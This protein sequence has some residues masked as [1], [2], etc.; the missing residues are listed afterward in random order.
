MQNKQLS[1]RALHL[2]TINKGAAL[3][4]FPSRR[5]RNNPFWP[6]PKAPKRPSVGLHHGKPDTN[7]KPRPANTATV[8]KQNRLWLIPFSGKRLCLFGTPLNFQPVC[9]KFAIQK[10]PS[11]KILP[12]QPKAQ[13]PFFFSCFQ[14][15]TFL[16]HFHTSGTPTGGSIVRKR[17]FPIP[18]HFFFFELRN[19]SIPGYNDQLTLLSCNLKT[20]SV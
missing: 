8:K 18:P 6:L 11:N 12:H 2:S 9:V 19:S 5:C 1:R 14:S 10:I 15:K 20:T 13:T 17:C 4:C 16:S 3:G 7:G